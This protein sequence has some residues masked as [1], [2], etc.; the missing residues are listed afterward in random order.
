[1]KGERALVEMLA[2]ILR[3]ES[4]EVELGIGDDC[5]VLAAAHGTLVWTVDAQVDE[6]HFRREWLTYGDVGFRSFAAA[7]SD[8]VAMGAAPLGALSALTLD[9]PVSDSDVEALAVGQRDASVDAA[10]PILGGNLS[11]GATFSV[12][13]TVLGRTVGP[14]AVLR[15]GARPGDRL[16]VSGPVGLAHLGLLAFQKGIADDASLERCVQAFRRPRVRYDAAS[17]VAG[18]HAAIDVSDGLALDLSR[19]ADASGVCIVLSEGLLLRPGGEVLR[20]GAAR[21]EREPVE[22]AL[23]GGEDYVVAFASPP[24]API[25]DGY[26]V[27]GEVEEGQGV[28]LDDGQ[29]RHEVAARGHDH[30]EGR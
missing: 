15:G 27:I 1:M 23:H 5:A 6:V 4:A 20:D 10:A 17:V 28:F 29:G 18:A 9:A 12:T 8:V 14:R 11:R 19:L 16:L 30:F 25:P 24:N 13:T 3:S 21:L 22:A 7:A 2:R 26:W